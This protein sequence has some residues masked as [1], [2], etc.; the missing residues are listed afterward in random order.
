MAG[1]TSKVSDNPTNSDNPLHESSNESQ[2]EPDSGSPDPKERQKK[3]HKSRNSEKNAPR[4]FKFTEVNFIR[5]NT[6]T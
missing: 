3:S 5:F 2:I 6:K 1:K 4:I